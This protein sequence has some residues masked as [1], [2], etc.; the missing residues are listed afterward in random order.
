MRKALNSIREQEYKN[1]QVV[2]VEDGANIS[3][4]MITNE[5]SDLNIV[6]QA[7]GE[8]K[9]RC[10]AGNVGLKLAQGEYLNFL[11]DD[12]MLLPNHFQV[13]YTRILQ[14]QV[15]AA[16]AWAEEHQILIK[17]RET[18]EFVVKRKF[19]RYKQPFNRLLLCY[20]NYIPIQSI[21]FS[22]ELYDLYG[23]FDE[24]LEVLEDWDLW[25]RYAVHAD[26]L[27]VPEVTSVYYTPYKFSE[28][29]GRQ[30]QLDDGLKIVRE[31]HRELVVQC[32]TA[33]IGRDVDYLI[34]VYGNNRKGIKFYLKKI[35]DLICSK[36][37]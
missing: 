4:Q 36:N 23:G 29:T 34:N 26:F 17:N 37:N 35:R 30:K 28:K 18:Y 8:R 33:D 31:K 3:E 14:T 21:L 15:K 10:Y 27:M 16:Y 1:I 11:D 9:G 12:D 2:V 19:F 5:F 6:Y 24:N 13:L 25:V 32:S 7:T 20:M 22:R